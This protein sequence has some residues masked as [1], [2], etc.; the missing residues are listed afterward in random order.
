MSVVVSLR[1]SKDLKKLD[2]V[3]KIMD[4]LLETVEILSDPEMMKSIRV[5]LEDVKSGR[6]RELHDLLKEEG[7]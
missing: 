2:E 7:N 3:T 6:V 4:G 5:G 1:L